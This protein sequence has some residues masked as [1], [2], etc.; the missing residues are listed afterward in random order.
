[1]TDHD[2]QDWA[3]SKRQPGPSP[4]DSHA[5]VARWQ[6]RRGRRRLAIRVGSLVLAAAV[7]AFWLWPRQAMRST[8]VEPPEVVASPVERELAPGRHESHGD[9]IEVATESQVTVESPDRLVLDRGSVLIEA[10]PRP[11]DQPLAVHAGEAR[12]VVVG[13]RFSVSLDPLS[14]VVSEGVVAVEWHGDRTLVRAGEVYPPPPPEV[15]PA[16]PSLDVLRA[17]VVAGELAAARKAL[18]AHVARAPTDAE[19]WALLAQ[20]ATREDQPN[21]ARRA[22]QKVVA[23]GRPRAARRARFELARLLEDRPR[24]AIEWLEAYLADPGPWV[25]EARL[26]LGRAQRALQ[27]P[28][29]DATLRRVIADHPGTAAAATA[30]ALLG[31]PP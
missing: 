16:P 3:A 10:R 9:V 18:E 29:A 24:E 1:M 11:E 28:D 13:T 17:Q 19:A 27:D 7:V 31:D 21:R 2:L 5:L 4:E 8:T 23:H 15:P 20:V 22:W 25:P 6:R 26:R 14:V 12:V 30:R